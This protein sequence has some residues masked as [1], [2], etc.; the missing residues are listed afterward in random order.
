[1]LV[2]L[3]LANGGPAQRCANANGNYVLTGMI[4]VIPPPCSVCCDPVFLRGL[5]NPCQTRLSKK[6]VSRKKGES[7][8]YRLQA[9]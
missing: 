6:S 4:G 1:V 2:P 5:K 3:V 8:V 9:S 7:H